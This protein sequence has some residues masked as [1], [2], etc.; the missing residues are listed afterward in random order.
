[1]NFKIAGFRVLPENE[2]GF[3]EVL[4]PIRVVAVIE[5]VEGGVVGSDG[6]IAIVTCVVVVVV[7]CGVSVVITGMVSIGAGAIVTDAMDSG[8]GSRSLTVAKLEGEDGVG[9]EGCCWGS[10]FSSK[11]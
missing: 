7:T 5:S 3:G 6:D 11:S 8:C 9:E 2:G 4:V 10:G 1:M